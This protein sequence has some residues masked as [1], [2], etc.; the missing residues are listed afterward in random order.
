[1]TA[2]RVLVAYGTKN[3][4]TAEIAGWIA[5]ALRERGVEADVRPAGDVPDTD[6][7][8]AVI[9]GAGLYAGRW[10][11]DAVRFVRRHRTRLARQPVWLFS[12][13]PLDDSATDGNLPAPPGVTRLADRIDARAHIT[14]GGRLV[15]GAR[16]FIARQILRQGRGGDFRDRERIRAWAHSVADELLR[17]GAGGAVV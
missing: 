8:D 13:G 16:G 7:Y 1:M 11:H 3:G 4:S 12:S 14:F 17:A 10:Q 6:P 5:E 2:V 9:L 15:K